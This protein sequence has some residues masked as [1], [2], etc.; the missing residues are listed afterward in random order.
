MPA[1]DVPAVDT[2]IERHHNVDSPIW[3][4]RCTAGAGE[5]FASHQCSVVHAGREGDR[6]P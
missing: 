3:Y 2:R 5:D 1:A 6:S 4:R